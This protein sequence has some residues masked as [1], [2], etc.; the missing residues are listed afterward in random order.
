MKSVGEILKKA[1]VEKNLTLEESEKK[2]KIRAKFLAALE[3]NDYQKLPSG[4]YIRGF[5]KNYSEFLG[6]SSEKV[7]AIFRRQFDERKNLGLLPKGLSE[8]IK[9]ESN[10]PK[11]PLLGLLLF[12]LPF[13]LLLIYF[14]RGYNS[15]VKAPSLTIQNPKEQEVST[16]GTVEVSGQ[17]DPLAT[18]TINGQQ[19]SL[20][21]DGSF[22]Q[23]ISLT[24]GLNIL[25][26]VAKNKSGAEKRIKKTVR[27]VNSAPGE[28]TPKNP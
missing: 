10:L 4:V 21:G 2:I 6:L 20:S 26:F 7:L 5:V 14:W 28:A 9:K 16:G 23:K 22:N 12:L 27:V 19:I 24:P 13:I 18:L 3:A 8:P 17:T 15:Y 11:I 1:R 25:E